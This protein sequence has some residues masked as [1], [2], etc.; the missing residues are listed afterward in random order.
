MPDDSGGPFLGSPPYFTWLPR[1]DGE[2]QDGVKAS[3]KPVAP[4]LGEPFQGTKFLPGSHGETGRI[5]ILRKRA[6][7]PCRLP[8]GGPF[9]GTLFFTWFP[10]EAGED[11]D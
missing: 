1:G 9:R 3:Q 6:R 11:Q 8:W 10:W 2:D 4:P 7:S 5:R